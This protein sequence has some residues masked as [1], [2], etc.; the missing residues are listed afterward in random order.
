MLILEFSIIWGAWSIG[1]GAWSQYQKKFSP[2]AYT[3]LRKFGSDRFTNTKVIKQKVC[4]LTHTSQP[5]GHSQID[6]LECADHFYIYFAI[7]IS[8]IFYRYKLHTKLSNP[9]PN[10]W[11]VVNNKVYNNNVKCRNFTKN[12]KLIIP[13]YYGSV[14]IKMS[15]FLTHLGV[16]QQFEF[17]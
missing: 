16:Y 13:T 2:S 10:F 1:G 14:G 5:A 11:C 17:N 6:Y 3:N 4:G 9:I 15:S 7:S 12:D 8:D